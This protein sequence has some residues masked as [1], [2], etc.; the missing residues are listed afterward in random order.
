MI[1][2]SLRIIYAQDTITLSTKFDK[3][4]N[5]NEWEIDGTGL[6]KISNNTLILYKAGNPSGIIRRPAALAI[7][8][9][10]KFENVTIEVD[11]RT[12]ADTKILQ[13]D[14][15]IILGYNSP[16]RFY[17]IHLSAISD[18]VHNGI[19]L[20]DNA[21]RRRI[22]T[23]NRKPLIKDQEW[24]HI[25]VERNVENGKIKVFVDNSF[26][27]ALQT[28]DKTILSGRIGLG[29]FDD[30]AEFK[31]LFTAASDNSLYKK[32]KKITDK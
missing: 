25:K 19:F 2:I 16:S 26:N 17:Y 24:H 20:V 8:K 29:S 28:T 3:P 4:D 15:V 11:V 14:V 31:N 30:T 32:H 1:T 10:R 21:N 12:T 22:D 23:G 7:M 27:S 9:S 6:W 13:R 5:I 18:D